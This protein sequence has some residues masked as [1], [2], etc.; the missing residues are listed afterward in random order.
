[1]RIAAS[2][3]AP[4]SPRGTSNTDARVDAAPR[5]DPSSDGTNGLAC[6]LS[7]AVSFASRH[8]GRRAE[9]MGLMLDCAGEAGVIAACDRQLGRRIVLGALECVA[10]LSRPGAELQV[11]VR[12]LKGAV[13]LRVA[14]DDAPPALTGGDQA[15]LT[16]ARALVDQAGGSMVAERRG[17][18]LAVSIRLASA[19]ARSETYRASL[20]K[21]AY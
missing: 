10:A 7:E 19:A 18:H 11:A 21:G 14:S 20:A 9:T 16:A 15:G 5:P 3:R 2:Q 8:V 13:L 6:D 17:L 1:M 4:E 12:R